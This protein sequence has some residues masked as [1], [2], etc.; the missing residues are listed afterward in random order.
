MIYMLMSDYEEILED[1]KFL[2]DESA[3]LILTIQFMNQTESYSYY[4]RVGFSN[5]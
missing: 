4:T 3:S 1:K 5:H 2:L